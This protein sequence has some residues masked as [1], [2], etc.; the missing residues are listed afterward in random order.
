MLDL[1]KPTGQAKIVVADKPGAVY[2]NRNFEVLAQVEKEW[3]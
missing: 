1:S 3:E 2:L